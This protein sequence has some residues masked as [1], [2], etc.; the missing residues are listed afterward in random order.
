[1][2]RSNHRHVQP[3]LFDTIQQ[4]PKK[5]GQR[6]DDSW[7]GTFPGLSRARTGYRE[8]F[9]R[10]D[11]SPLAVLYADEPSR[12]NTPVNV[13]VGLEV[14]KA[15]FGWSDE[16]LYDAFL[17]NLQVRYALGLWDIG[18]GNF[19]LRTLYNFRWRLSQH[20]QETGENLLERVCPGR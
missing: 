5:V 17:F 16:E 6:L 20:M 9:C 14:I 13:L 15:G 10:I 3:G 18:S 4:L 12:P 11:E 8:V 7:A 2:F 1:M 19:E